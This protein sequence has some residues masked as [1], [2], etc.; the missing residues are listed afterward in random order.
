MIYIQITSNRADPD[1][2]ALWA[3]VAFDGDDVR[4][5]AAREIA[6]G[7]VGVT[8][9]DRCEAAFKI[10]MCGVEVATNK[11][12]TADLLYQQ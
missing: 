12:Y 8:D 11:G 9:P 10:I 3:T 4:I 2:A 7:C 1:A 5:N 6:E